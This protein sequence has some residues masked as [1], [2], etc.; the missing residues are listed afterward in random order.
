MRMSSAARAKGNQMG[1]HTRLVPKDGTYIRQMYD[2]FKANPATPMYLPGFRQYSR[3]GGALENL[4]NFYGLDIRAFGEQRPPSGRQ[5]R[6]SKRYWLVG[7]WFGKTY[8]DY[9]ADRRARE[10]RE[11]AK[12]AMYWKP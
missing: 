8:L 10:E 12:A 9:I 7:E 3:N 1:G 11:A 4:R 6:P 2:M 5:G